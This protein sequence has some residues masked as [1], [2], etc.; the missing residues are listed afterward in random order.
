MGEG[1]WDLIFKS[2]KEFQTDFIVSVKTG[3][4]GLDLLSLW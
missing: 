2:Y 3:G 1:D 4:E